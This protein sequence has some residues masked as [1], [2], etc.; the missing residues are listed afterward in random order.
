MPYTDWTLD[1]LRVSFGLIIQQELLLPN[2][3]PISVPA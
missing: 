2:V 1:A 3:T